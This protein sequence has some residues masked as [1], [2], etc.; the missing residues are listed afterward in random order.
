MDV[1]SDKKITALVATQGTNRMYELDDG[2]WLKASGGTV[3]WRN[4]NPGNLKFGYHDSADTTVHT[5]RTKEEALAS[6]QTNYKGVVA[7]DQWGNAVFESYE[8]GRAAQ[9][10]LL[11]QKMGDKTVEELVKAY[12]KPDYSGQTHYDSQIKTIYATASAQGIDLHGKTVS[13][14]SKKEIDALADGLSKAEGWRVGTVEHMKPLSADQL[15]ESMGAQKKSDAP[16]ADHGN[17]LRKGDHNENVRH[18]QESLNK[19]GVTGSNGKP[20]EPDTRFGQQT[21]EA[22]QAFQRSHGLKDDGIVGNQTMKA[23]NDAT[24]QAK[25][26]PASTQDQVKHGPLLSDKAH[27]SNGMYE[28]A[29][30]GMQDIER[31]LGQSSGP[32]TQNVSGA[33]TT[34]A[35]KAGMDRIDHVA[36]SDDANKAYAMKGDP[37]SPFKQHAEVD[38]VKAANT[39]LAQSSAQAMDHA[40]SQQATQQNTQQQE[41]AQ[42]HA[43]QQAQ[44]PQQAAPAAPG[45]PR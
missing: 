38:V 23:I 43:Q 18:V 14:L 8:A 39:S 21:K 31:R 16:H 15:K 3:A 36:L 40:Q 27:P 28:Q 34:A 37:S 10:K 44:Q 7:L 17:T 1:V 29:L 33:L 30:A 22:V 4:N 11:T 32:H 5:K 24:T 13:E 12:S 6:A 20:L 2:S 9:E 41:Q 19:L 42:S 45:M 35:L 26:G 25:T